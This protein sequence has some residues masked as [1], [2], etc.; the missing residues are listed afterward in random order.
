[1]CKPGID[2]LL[3]RLEVDVFVYIHYSIPALVKKVI[4]TPFMSQVTTK[5]NEIYYFTSSGSFFVYSFLEISLLLRFY[6]Y[7]MI[8]QH[9]LKSVLHLNN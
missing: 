3:F 5:T 2:T 6:I 8:S 1:M 9:T 4:F 7:K